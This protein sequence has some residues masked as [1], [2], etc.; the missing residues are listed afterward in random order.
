[1]EDSDAFV[2]LDS[3]AED[4]EKDLAPGSHPYIF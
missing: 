3:E 1:M 4:E 2:D